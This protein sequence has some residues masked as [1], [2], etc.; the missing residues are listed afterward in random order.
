MLLGTTGTPKGCLLTHRGL[1]QAIIAL[2][3]TAADVR[4]EDIRQG[5][6]LAVA[7]LWDF[8][9]VPWRC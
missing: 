4:M 1:S 8:G 7:C 2:S 5:H 6:Y 9:P 3:S